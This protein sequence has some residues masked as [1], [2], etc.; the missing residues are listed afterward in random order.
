MPL[1]VRTPSANRDFSEIALY[2]AEK[3]LDG[4]LNWIDGLDQTLHL[5]A[6]NPLLGEAVDHLDKGIRRHTYEKYLIF[7]V[8]L[9]DGV[10]VRRILHGSRDITDLT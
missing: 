8:P 9:E 10:E 7:Y 4:A 2:L 1:I 6:S 5:L 3:S